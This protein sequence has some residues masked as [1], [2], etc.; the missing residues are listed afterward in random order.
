[1]SSGYYYKIPVRPI[2]KQ[3]PVYAPGHEPSGYMDWLKQ[4]EPTIVW[5]D[6]GHRPALKTEADWIHA[7]ETVFDSPLAI[8]GF[9]AKL[10]RIASGHR[11]DRY[12]CAI[13]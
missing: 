4:R 9:G 13:R 11:L 12:A 7:G 8:A 10:S 6:A 5:D 3:Y 2:Y 1:V